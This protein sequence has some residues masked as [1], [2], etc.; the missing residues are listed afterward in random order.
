MRNAPLP[1]IPASH[2]EPFSDKEGGDEFGPRRESGIELDYAAD[3][4]EYIGDLIGKSPDP[5]RDGSKPVA[6][7]VDGVGKLPEVKSKGTGR[8]EDETK[9]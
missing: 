5:S 1:P 6:I 3:S 8:E 2:Q 9:V 4:G 7:Q